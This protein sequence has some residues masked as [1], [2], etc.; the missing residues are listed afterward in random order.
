[1]VSKGFYPLNT[2][3]GN[4]AK[5]L[6]QT[7]KTETTTKPAFT[8]NNN[9]VVSVDEIPCLLIGS[10]KLRGHD[11]EYKLFDIEEMSRFCGFKVTQ[12]ILL[13][14]KLSTKRIILGAVVPENELT[15]LRDSQKGS[16]GLVGV[17]GKEL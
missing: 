4:M 3:K 5:L 12:V 15:K 11:K 2:C 13:Q 6:Q 8:I 10:F 14:S 16:T 7:D 9:P 1:M 17:D